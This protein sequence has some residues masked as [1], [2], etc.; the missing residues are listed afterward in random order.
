MGTG[1]VFKNL[2]GET[3]SLPAFVHMTGSGHSGVFPAPPVTAFVCTY[4]TLMPPASGLGIVQIPQHI[5]WGYI[6]VVTALTGHAIQL[7]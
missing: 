7:H 2:G 4:D 6:P 5:A 1:K 3:E